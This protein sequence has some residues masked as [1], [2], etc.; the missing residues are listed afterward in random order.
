[1]LKESVIENVLTAALEQYADF[2]E[3][4]VKQTQ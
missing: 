4:Y 1:M 3:I 2:G